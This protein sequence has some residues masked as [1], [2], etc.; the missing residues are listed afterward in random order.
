MSKTFSQVNT[1]NTADTDYVDVT[2]W[3]P[4]E[5]MGRGRVAW[6]FFDDRHVLSPPFST[7][8]DCEDYMAGAKQEFARS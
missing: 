7:K 2:P 5:L 6:Y 4:I 8:L 1:A 3:T